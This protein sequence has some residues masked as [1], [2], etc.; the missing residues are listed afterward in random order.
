MVSGSEIVEDY[1]RGVGRVIWAKGNYC[2]LEYTFL[3]IYILF[4]GI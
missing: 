4:V 2:S 1:D 3:E